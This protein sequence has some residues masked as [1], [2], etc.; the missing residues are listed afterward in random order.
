[1]GVEK[2]L[3]VPHALQ[4]VAAET[5][6]RPDKLEEAIASFAESNAT[7]D[8]WDEYRLVDE[9]AAGAIRFAS[10][11]HWSA[12]YGYRT[13]QTYFGKMSPERDTENVETMSLDGLL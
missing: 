10:D 4:A 3:R 13:P 7:V 9:V 2:G 12:N 1:M 5:F 8:V 6:G 11:K